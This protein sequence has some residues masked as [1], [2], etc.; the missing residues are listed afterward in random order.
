VTFYFE[1]LKNLVIDHGFCT[2]CGTCAAV[3]SIVKMDN[4]VSYVE[5]LDDCTGCGHCFTMCT[6]INI[7]YENIGSLFQ[8]ADQTKSAMC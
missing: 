4:G 6:Q 2:Q 1:D 5:D 3:C 8:K 7:G